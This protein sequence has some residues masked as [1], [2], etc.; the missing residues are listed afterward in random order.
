LYL[1]LV[2]YSPGVAK[3]LVFLLRDYGPNDKERPTD[4]VNRGLFL[5]QDYWPIRMAH[6]GELTSANKEFLIYLDETDPG[7]DWF[8]IRLIHEGWTLDTVALDEVRRVYLVH[9]QGGVLS[10]QG[11]VQNSCNGEG[12]SP[13]SESQ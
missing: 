11:G 6:Y 1:Q 3:R 7:H 13:S 4:T 9:R 5:L 2:H 8:T 10:Q 12:A